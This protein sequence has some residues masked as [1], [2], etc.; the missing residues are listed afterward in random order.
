MHEAAKAVD[1]KLAKAMSQEHMTQDTVDAQFCS[2]W[3]KLEI[4]R[5]FDQNAK[6]RA[7]LKKACSCRPGGGYCSAC[8]SLY[9]IT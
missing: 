4:H 5:L 1:S 8:T 9:S 2:D 6:L 3:L 7:A